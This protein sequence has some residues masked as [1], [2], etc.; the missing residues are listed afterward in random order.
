MPMKQKHVLCSFAHS[1]AGSCVGLC[2]G[3]ELLHCVRLQV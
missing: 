2:E 3:P 1:M